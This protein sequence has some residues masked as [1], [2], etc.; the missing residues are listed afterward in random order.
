LENNNNNFK[1]KKTMFKKLSIALTLV[2]AIAVGTSF[3]CDP[4]KEIC[5]PRD[6]NLNFAFD[7]MSDD[8][9][10]SHRGNDSASSNAFGFAGGNLNVSANAD[11]TH[12]EF[13]GTKWYHVFSSKYYE[14]VDN[15]AHVEGYGTADSES[16]AWSWTRDYGTTS[17][18]GAGAKTEGDAFTFGLATG[19]EGCRETVDSQVYV[20]G[21]VYQNNYA[22]E[23]G[24]W[25][26]QGVDGGNMSG[27]NFYTSDFDSASGR[28]IA[29][30]TNYIDGGMITKGKTEVS[31]DPY[32]SYRSITAMTENMVRVDADAID[33]QVFGN[34]GIGG[35]SQSRNGSFAGGNAGFGYNGVT[36]GNGNAQ[37][38][39]N[40][41]QGQNNT[42]VT[43]SGSAHS[44]SDGGSIQPD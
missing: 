18:A 7:G 13:I 33:S 9:S 34:G 20:G 31:I 22:A 32:G 24:Y 5:G 25:D 27:G 16:K 29:M 6:A 2:L 10:S 19:L 14:D 35:N 8:Q 23:I 15:A 43:V 39:A 44:V 30:D 37:M 1:E 17:K 28:G 42:T 12:L 38:N 36:Y 41:Y 3:A 26:N 21:N 11:G 40:V 4:R